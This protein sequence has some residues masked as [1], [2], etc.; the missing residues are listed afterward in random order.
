M[1]AKD[2]KSCKFYHE[3]EKPKPDG[4]QSLDFVPDEGFGMC[5]RYPPVLRRPL[6]DKEDAHSVMAERSVDFWDHPCVLG[7]D[8]C[9]EWKRK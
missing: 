7:D 4:C 1:K 3:F 2:C 6:G 5:K 9:G 8:W